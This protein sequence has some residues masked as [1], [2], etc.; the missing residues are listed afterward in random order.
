MLPGDIKVWLS[1][2]AGIARE[3]EDV[4]DLDALADYWRTWRASRDP[5]NVFAPNPLAEYDPPHLWV[6]P[7]GYR[8]SDRVW[9]TAGETRRK[10]DAMVDEGI[11]QGRG[12][13]ALSRDLEEY[14]HPGRQIVRTKAPYGTDASYDAMRLA[15]TEITRAASK[16]HEAAALD[17]PF[18]TGLKWKLS[19]Q[20]PC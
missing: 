14:L 2:Q 11:R 19:P 1:V 9:R 15:R 12:A 18:V 10:V 4:I 3:Q 17:N 7:N 8:L 16:A 13:L 6:D 20:H 5:Q